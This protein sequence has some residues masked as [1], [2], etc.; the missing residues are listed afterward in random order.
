MKIKLILILF[1]LFKAKFYVVAQPAL[2]EKGYRWVL[3]EQL[4]DEFNGAAFDLNKWKNTDASKWIGR[5]PGLFLEKAATQV[6]GNLCLTTDILTTP[7]VVNGTTFTH[8]GAHIISKNRVKP[9]SYIECKMQANKTFMSSTFW[10][11]NYANE[12]TVAC[13]KR[14]TE[15]DI[16]ECIGY[17]TTKIQTQHMG[18]NSHSRNVPA[19]CNQILSGSVGNNVALTDKAYNRYFTYGVWWKG[20]GEFLFYLDGKY[21]YTIT[22]VADFDIDMYIK[23]VCETYDWNPVPADGGMTGSWDDRTTFYDWVRTYN[24]LPIDEVA[25][26]SSVSPKVFTEEINFSDIPSAVLVNNLSFPVIYKAN[27][28][29]KIVLEI[30]NMNGHVVASIEKAV[31]AGY[32]NLELKMSGVISKGSYMVVASL[33]NS[34]SGALINTCQ[35]QIQ[36]IDASKLNNTLISEYKLFPNP[37]DRTISIDGLNAPTICDVLSIDGQVLFS[38]LI[39]TFQSTIDLKPLQSGIYLLRIKSEN[40][41]VLKRFVKL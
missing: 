17:P 34:L 18:S 20:P 28:D 31:L 6:N 38:K 11:I 25:I 36:I 1:A 23:M 12:S 40:E 5:A 13:Q 30:K 21:Q 15:L 8:Q 10:L 4:S 16:Q 3:N 32:G 41:K 37:A 29:Q 2:P 24:Y 26:A 7:Q 9:G 27:S 22:P 39:D 33:Y 35:Q 14:T 19:A